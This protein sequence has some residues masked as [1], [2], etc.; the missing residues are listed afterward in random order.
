MT[1]NIK[2]YLEAVSKNTELAQKLN[3]MTKEDIIASAKEL[4]I[5][6][7]E[8]DFERNTE[9]SDDELDAV[10]GGGKCV[11][12]IGGG[13]ESGGVSQTCYC[14]GSG[15][16]YMSSGDCRCECLAGGAGFDHVIF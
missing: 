10:A 4:G 6:L 12:V 2:K 8:A 9:L 5:A 15:G 13:G 14:V 1:E 16:G 7:T 3:T 11:C